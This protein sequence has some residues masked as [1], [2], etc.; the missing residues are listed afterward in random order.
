MTKHFNSYLGNKDL[1]QVMMAIKDRC[2]AARRELVEANMASKAT[3]EEELPKIDKLGRKLLNGY[4]KIPGEEFLRLSEKYGERADRLDF[5]I[6]Q[7]DQTTLDIALGLMRELQAVQANILTGKSSAD[8]L[9][10][11]I[12]EYM[13]LYACELG[14]TTTYQSVA[15]FLMAASTGIRRMQRMLLTNERGYSL[16]TDPAFLAKVEEIRAILKTYHKLVRESGLSLIDPEKIR[17]NA[18]DAENRLLQIL[19]EDRKDKRERRK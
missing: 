18:N 3:I 14:V 4:E 13:I 8:L 19:G 1:S 12:E 5:A 2:Q 15:G 11:V 16:G 17:E 7:R 6:L 9:R 10:L